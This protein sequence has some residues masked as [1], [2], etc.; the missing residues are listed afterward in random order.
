MAGVSLYLLL[1]LLGQ[2]PCKSDRVVVRCGCM[3]SGCRERI[4]FMLHGGGVGTERNLH[5]NK[6][7]IY[8]P[9]NIIIISLL[10]YKVQLSPLE[11]HLS[12]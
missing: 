10:L 4:K 5:G 6:S 2:G 12:R 7:P 9:R 8:I 11:A 1:L 3:T